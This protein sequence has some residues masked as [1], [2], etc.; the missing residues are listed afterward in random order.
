MG[1]KYKQSDLKQ[2]LPKWW[3]NFSPDPYKIIG[4]FCGKPPIHYL[5][6]LTIHLDLYFQRCIK[7]SANEEQEVPMD[8]VFRWINDLTDTINPKF[9]PNRHFAHS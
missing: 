5:H 9:I 7:V 1:K 8:A 6:Q 3:P 2:E 4:N